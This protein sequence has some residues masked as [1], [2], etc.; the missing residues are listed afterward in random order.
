MAKIQKLTAE[1]KAAQE[2][3]VDRVRRLAQRARDEVAKKR[4]EAEE[5]K[6]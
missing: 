5:P 2:G 6:A 1:E 3:N 4:A